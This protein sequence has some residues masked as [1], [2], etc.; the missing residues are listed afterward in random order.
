MPIFELRLGHRDAGP[1]QKCFEQRPFATG[2]LNRARAV[3]HGPG[4]EI[5][6]QVADLDERIRVAAVSPRHRIQPRGEFRQIERLD[7][8]VVGAGIEA[9][10]AVGDLVERRQD[11]DRRHAALG[12][13]LFEKGDAQSVREHQIE[14]DEI[15]CRALEMFARRIE[16][17]HPVHRVEGGNLLAHGLSEDSIVFDQ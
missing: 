16:P 2:K 11:D 5:D 7:H 14:Q 3:H 15:V 4:G 13:K 6:A 12:S 17:C 8:V 1:L 10:D 9:R